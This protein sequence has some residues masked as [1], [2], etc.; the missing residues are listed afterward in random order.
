[1]HSIPT[2]PVDDETV[3]KARGLPWQASDQD[4]ANF[5]RGLNIERLVVILV[6][7]TYLTSDVVLEAVPCIETASRQFLLL[8]RGFGLALS[9]LKTCNNK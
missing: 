5:F 4:I 2:E 6:T 7:F 1:V 9:A 3:V 8:R